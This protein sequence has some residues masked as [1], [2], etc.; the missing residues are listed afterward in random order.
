MADKAV[1]ATLPKLSGSNWLEWKKEAETF[2]MLAGLD[3][4]I[5]AEEALTTA[6]WTAKDRK[7]YA[8]LFF[9]IE[10]NYRAPIID[11]K[12]G[13]EAWKKLVSE[14]EKDS[15]T[16]RMALRQQF[17]SVTHNPAV[18]IVIFIDTVFSIV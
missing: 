5:D 15:A 14:Y 8:Y 10:L 9:L 7:T 4:I 6:K 1:L 13:R 3:G 17:Y 12:S 16:T 18:G 11:M 2:L